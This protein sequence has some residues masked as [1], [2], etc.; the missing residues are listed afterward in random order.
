MTSSFP[1]IA[2]DLLARL[3]KRTPLLWLNPALGNALPNGAPC[4]ADI[5]EEN[6]SLERCAGLMTDLFPELQ[7]SAGLIESPLMRVDRLQQ[8]SMHVADCD[9]AWFIKSDHALPIAGSVKAR[10]GFHE[11]LAFAEKLALEHGVLAHDGDRRELAGAA[12]RELF[13]QY[14][15]SVGSTGNL[16]LSIGVMAAA[17]GFQSVVHMSTDAKAWKKDR[18]RKCGVQVVEHAGDYAQAVAAG[19]AQSLADPK[20]YFVDDENSLMLFLGYAVAAR[21]LAAQLTALNRPVDG[22]HP[23]FVYIPCG[24]GG[25]P[26]GITFGLKALFFE[27]VH[28]FFAEPVAS[29]CMLVQLAAGETASTSVYDI[30]LDNRTEADGLAVGQA[31]HLVS[32]LMR[33]Q[34]SGVFTVADAQLHRHLYR[35]AQTEGVLLEPSAAAG[36]D[37]PRWLTHS[38]QGQAYLRQHGLERHMASATHIVWTTGG[39]LVPREEHEQFQARGQLLAAQDELA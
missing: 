14:T 25:A 5:D 26:G 22:T 7:S 24:V 2:P 8:A 32:P 30:G 35:V 23:L 10:G 13:A 33:S 17:L 21:R 1:S 6:A 15:V 16:G 34:L 29:P 28:C 37:G 18:L 3:Q 27:H 38:D 11:V 9:A 31:S 39:S 36:F 20:G 4:A 19:R 12:A